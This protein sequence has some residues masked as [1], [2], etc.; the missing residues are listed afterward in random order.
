MFSKVQ[1]FLVIFQKVFK[2]FKIISLRE[3]TLGGNQWLNESHRFY[4]KTESNEEDPN[5]ENEEKKEQITSDYSS[6]IDKDDSF[7]VTLNPMKIRTFIIEV[8]HYPLTH[9]TNDSDVYIE[10]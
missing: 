5:S 4:W 6:Q 7:L 10:E 2:Q 3:T 9:E 1:F 8:E